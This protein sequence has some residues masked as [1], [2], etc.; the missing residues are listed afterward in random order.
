MLKI[1]SLSNDWGRFRLKDINLEVE[2][3]EFLVI[4]GPSGAGKTLLLESIAGFTIPDSGKILKA[5]EDITSYSPENRDIGF[6][7]QDFA[8]FPH[9]SV[10]QNIEFGIKD[11]ENSKKRAK[12][13]ASFLGIDHLLDAAPLTLSGGEKQRV[14]LARALATEPGLMLFDEPL[15]SLDE[16]IQEKMRKEIK[17]IHEQ[18]N[19][20]SIYVTHNQAEAMFLAD[21]IAIMMEGE[22]VQVGEPENIF[23]GPINKQIAEFVGVENIYNGTI[24]EKDD[25]LAK[26]NIGKKDIEVIT[27]T[28]EGKNVRIMIRPEEIFIGTEKDKNSKSARNQLE[29]VI[30]D[31]L[32]QGSLVRLELSNSIKLIAYVTRKSLSELDLEKGRKVYASFKASSVHTV[33]R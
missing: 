32:D 26:V 1:K 12:D 27:E 24:T 28:A 9:L 25:N 17:N 13:L 15:S 19:L 22:I 23:Y 29:L 5:K 33:E 30:D 11:Q 3:G 8:L 21:R 2:K 14:T 31:I 20:T 18:M 7:Y 16:R 4:L 10:R 6:V